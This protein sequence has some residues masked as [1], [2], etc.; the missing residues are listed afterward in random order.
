[1]NTELSIEEIDNLTYNFT[2]HM[3]GYYYENRDE[4]TTVVESLASK[5]M[6]R[7]DDVKKMMYLTEYGV[8]IAAILNL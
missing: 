3:N 1:M 2:N 4:L 7:F 8:D 6:Y 5:G